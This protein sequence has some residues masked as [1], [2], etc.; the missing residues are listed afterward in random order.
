MSK[1]KVQVTRWVNW[2]D[3]REHKFTELPDE[4]FDDAWKAVVEDMKSNGYKLS[5]ESHQ[6]QPN[7]VPLI[8]GKYTFELSMRQWGRL[9]TEVLGIKGDYAYC[10]WAW[11]CPK[12][13]TEILPA[14]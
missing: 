10:I 1:H 7:C 3:G 8:N 5:G 14:G 12:G 4:L 9:M 2:P 13:E 11:G 6:N